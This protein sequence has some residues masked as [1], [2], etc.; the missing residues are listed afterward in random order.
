MDE[1]Q[2]ENRFKNFPEKKMENIFLVCVYLPE[3]MYVKRNVRIVSMSVFWF[4]IRLWC[5]AVSLH[6]LYLENNTREGACKQK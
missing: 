4:V 3:K 5:F 2:S 6:T 1:T